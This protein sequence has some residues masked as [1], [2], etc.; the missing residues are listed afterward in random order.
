VRRCLA[1][2]PDERYQS[3]KEVAIELK[4]LRRELEA[5][6]RANP[7]QPKTVQ[8]AAQSSVASTVETKPASATGSPTPSVGYTS[9][10]IKQRKFVIAL[11]ALLI[12]IGAAG[13][14][15]YLRGR[16]AE[17]AIESI[18]VLP[19]VNES[20][21]PNTEYLS[22]G[23]TESIISNLSQLPQLKIMARATVFRFKGKE[24]D[25]QTVGQKLNVRAVLT[26]RLL[27]QGDSLVI[28][29]EL[30]DVAD[31]SQL[32]GTEYNR[33]L[34]DVLALQQDMSREISERLRLQLTSEEHKRLTA[35]DTTNAE[36]YQYY[37]RGRYFW[38]KRT[39]DGLRKA[40]EQFQQA[41]DRD[42]NYALG[43][44]GL[45]DSQL[46]LQPDA[47]RSEDENYAK[48]KAYAERALQIDDSLAEAHTSL[49]GIN[50]LTW[51]WK[52]AERNFQRAIDL[53]PNYPTAHHWR[54]V[55]LQDLGRFD[56]ALTSL[57]RAQELDPLSRVIGFARALVHLGKY[58]VTACIEQA[59]KTIDWT[60]IIMGDM[61]F[62]ATPISNSDFTGKH[63]KS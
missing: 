29:T 32:W 14:G 58:D 38:N 19:F 46:L 31:G 52:D 40:I 21:D 2:Y 8:S 55:F 34:S 25:P 42:P 54:G 48:A 12:V 62:S 18:A 43:Y 22:D 7:P 6:G 26:G 39:A 5:L 20:N 57:K 50:S 45:A 11:A 30:V 24:I 3:I 15:L 35:R 27:Q 16:I 51:K 53:N 13:V 1:K 37:L 10:A 23:I 33:K 56:E 9:S 36:A 63:L 17:P 49:A 60:Q 41:I 61:Q 4:D 59:K 44:V 28:R 47:S